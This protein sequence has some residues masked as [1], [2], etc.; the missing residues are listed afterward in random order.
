MTR[1]RGARAGSRASLAERPGSWR[2]Y[3]VGIDTHSKFIAVTVLV[4]LYGQ[5]IEKC[6]KRHFDTS[7]SGLSAGREWVLATLRLH[8]CCPSNPAADLHYTIESTSCYHYPVVRRWQGKPSIVNPNLIKQGSRKTDDIDSGSLAEMDLVGRWPASYVHT[9]AQQV[10]RVLLRLHHKADRLAGRMTN[11]LNSQ[12]LKFGV[13]LSRLGSLAA[14]TVRPHVEDLLAGIRP[15]VPEALDC[16]DDTGVP[17]SL[18]GPLLALYEEH[19]LAKQRARNLWRRVEDAFG[20]ATYWTGAGEVDG[21]Q[22]RALL[23]TIPGV[24]AMSS[25]WLL[26]EVADVR[27]FGAK[28]PNGLVAWAGC[29]LS[30]RV[31][32]GKVTSYTRRKGHPHLHWL[33]VQ[34]GQRVLAGSDPLGKWG[35]KRVQRGGKGAKQRAVGAIARRITEAAYFVL[36]RGTPWQPSKALEGLANEQEEDRGPEEVPGGDD[37]GPV[38]PPPGDGPEGAGPAGAAAVAPAGA[39]GHEGPPGRGGGA[40][41]GVQRRHARPAAA[42]RGER[43]AGRPDLGRDRASAGRS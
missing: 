30:L 22:A 4:P 15:C 31:S 3:G 10:V 11:S 21:M 37:R 23:E 14:A 38:G 27:R 33:L 6:S 34:A 9:D 24:G 26:A 7:I 18:R 20:A 8:N 28:G 5:G 32:A 41:G 1:R 42:G 25:A 35:Q 29:D 13:T 2:A 43:L 39:E 12:L 17:E 36:M 16:L 40:P 19:D